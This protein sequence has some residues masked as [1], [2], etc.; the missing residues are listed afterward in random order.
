MISHFLSEYTQKHDKNTISGNSN[1]R[2]L[3]PYQ[4]L[5]MN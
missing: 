5:E 4:A 1:E 2:T 3:S